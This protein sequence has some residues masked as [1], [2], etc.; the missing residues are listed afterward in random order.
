MLFPPPDILGTHECCWVTATEGLALLSWP[1]VLAGSSSSV[2]P[3]GFLCPHP[4][5]LQLCLESDV[6]TRSGE[7]ISGGCQLMLNL[8]EKIV[9]LSILFLP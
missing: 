3:T 4:P 6:G 7:V 1:L 5:P 8:C 9:P 2:H